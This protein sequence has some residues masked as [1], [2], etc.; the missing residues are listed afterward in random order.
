MHIRDRFDYVE[1]NEIEK[2]QAVKKWRSMLVEE[3]PMRLHPSIKKMSEAKM[4]KVMDMMKIRMRFIKDIKNHAYLFELPDYQTNLGQG[5]ITKLKQ[6]ALTNKQI[7]ADL[8]VE[9]EKISEDDFTLMNL[10][11]A[12]SLYLYE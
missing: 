4:L 6:P 12:C 9:M 10:N 7:L 8:L 1:G 5:F 2:R 3:M 11:K